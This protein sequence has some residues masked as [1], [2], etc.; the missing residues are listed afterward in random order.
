MGLF[1]NTGN[2]VAQSADPGAL[3]AGAI[4]SDTDANRTLRRND[5][6]SAWVEIGI[7]VI[8]SANQ[9]LRTNS[10]GDGIEF[11]DPPTAWQELG[12]TTLAAEADTI[13]VA[14]FAA[15]NY[16]QITLF[17]KNTD[18]TV[19]TDLEFN[20]DQNMIYAT[21][22]SANGGAEVEDTNDTKIDG[23]ISASA[24][25]GSAFSTI[26]MSNYDDYEK[27]GVFVS[28]SGRVNTASTGRR[29]GSFL[30]N[31][32][33][34]VTRVDMDNTA[35]GTYDVGSEIVVYGRD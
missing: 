30:Y 34:Q 27:T 33:T 32:S 22:Y 2:F 29:N 9:H 24:S 35:A 7:G 17:Q 12:R 4:W 1:S 5:A 21:R 20:D 11:A 10:A 31:T 18:N 8:G 6:D 16:L 14:G 15:R 3:G 28:M 19:T 13:S 26:W 25:D 23:I